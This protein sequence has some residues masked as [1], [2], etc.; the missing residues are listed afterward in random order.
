[1]RVGS[2]QTPAPQFVEARRPCTRDHAVADDCWF[3]GLYSRLLPSHAIELAAVYLDRR[4]AAI[5]AQQPRAKPTARQ[6]QD[7]A[8]LIHLCG[9]G[10][11]KAFARRGFHLAP[12]QRRRDH[13]AARYLASVNA[14]THQF[15]QLS[16][17]Q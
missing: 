8:A 1:S 14:L 4:V 12:G 13:E 5:L 16:A 10:P 11:A 15:Q 17:A 2:D 7:L 9:A 6:L 3:T